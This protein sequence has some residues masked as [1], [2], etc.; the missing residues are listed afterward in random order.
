MSKQIS[1]ILQ[2][3]RNQPQDVINKILGDTYVLPGELDDVV[4]EYEESIDPQG[5]LERLAEQISE[6]DHESINAV[7]DSYG[8]KIVGN[9]S[10]TIDSDG[11]DRISEILTE[12]NDIL[13]T[14]ECV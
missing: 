8:F 2:S 9:T 12:V 11:R 5:A 10:L 7:G 6:W 3:L 1:Q 4:R 13:R 14:G